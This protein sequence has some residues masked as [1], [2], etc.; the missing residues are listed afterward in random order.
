MLLQ[1]T[2]VHD[3][4]KPGA[5]SAFGG[6]VMDNAFLHPNGRRSDANSGFD[7]IGN[8][9]GP[10]E[11]VDDVD[12]LANVFQTWVTPLAQHRTLIGIDGNDAVADGL[13]VFGHAVARAVAFARKTHNRDCAAVLQRVRDG[14]PGVQLQRRIL[15]GIGDF[16]RIAHFSL[17][18]SFRVRSA[19]ARPNRRA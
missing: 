4:D 11:N 8:E 1:N 16:G 19:P 10:A 2:G 9:F 18:S 5:A 14:I 13:H 7:D 6:F 3:D 15:A 17:Q 12:A